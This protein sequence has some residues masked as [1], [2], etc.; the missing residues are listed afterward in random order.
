VRVS[1]L[2]YALLG[3]L[4]ARKLTGYDLARLLREPLG[5]FWTARHSQI[6]P[7]LE[8]LRRQGLV[9]FQVIVQP[10]RPDKKLYTITRAGRAA[11]RKWVTEPVKSPVQRDEELLKT[12]SI[13]LGDPEEA[14][15]LYTDQLRIHRDLLQ[16]HRRLAASLERLQGKT[17]LDPRSPQFGNYAT[18]RRGIG[19]E[20]ERVAW[21]RWI[22]ARLS[23]PKPRTAKIRRYV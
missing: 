21:Y 14:A 7:E 10:T 1:T 16:R 6:Y 15:A 12:F 22:L 9:R 11:L 13:Q 2:G 23:A 4:A 20:R 5:F 19:Y 18:L 3:F 8:S 17:L